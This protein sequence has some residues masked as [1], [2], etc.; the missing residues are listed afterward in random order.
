MF[1]SELAPIRFV[2]RD[3][4]LADPHPPVLGLPAG[5][6]SDSP[7]EVDELWAEGLLRL[8]GKQLQLEYLLRGEIDTQPLR[9]E[10]ATV[11]IPLEALSTL[12]LRTGWRRTELLLQ[13]RSLTLFTEIPGAENGEVV[14]SLS[15]ENRVD[16]AALVAEAKLRAAE[17]LPP[18]RL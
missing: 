5:D 18:I 15:Y 16:A 7:L 14:L 12:D 1:D 2:V 13:A 10:V 11:K 8:D 4:S 17:A 6:M 9:T 3:V